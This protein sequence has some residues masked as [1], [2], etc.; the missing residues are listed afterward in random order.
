MVRVSNWGR[1]WKQTAP[2]QDNKPDDLSWSPPH[3]PGVCCQLSSWDVFTILVSNSAISLLYIF[4]IRIPCQTNIMAIAR[5]NIPQL[6][7]A[8][9]KSYEYVEYDAWPNLQLIMR[10]PEYPRM[11]HIVGNAI[12]VPSHWSYRNYMGNICKQ[13]ANMR[14][15]SSSHST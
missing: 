14:N 15:K 13:G 6:E 3:K 4:L 1:D 7:A 8:A 12:T 5:K 2:D 10:P 11:V 9:C